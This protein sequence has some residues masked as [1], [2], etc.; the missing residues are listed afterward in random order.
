MTGNFCR[1]ARRMRPFARHT[2]AFSRRYLLSRSILHSRSSAFSHAFS[3]AL[4]CSF[5][6]ALSRVFS[7]PLLLAFSHAFSRSLL[8][9][10]SH[11][12]SRSFFRAFSHSLSHAPVR[13]LVH[14]L[15]RVPTRPFLGKP[16]GDEASFFFGFW[17]SQTTK[18]APPPRII[19]IPNARDS[20]TSRLARAIAAPPTAPRQAGNVQRRMTRKSRR[21]CKR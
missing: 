1:R 17:H 7:C 19:R 2:R 4:S 11:A 14:I 15:V 3:H 9:S 10:L 5:S 16:P 6:H 21:F 8:H 13:T 12:L 20:G 18:A